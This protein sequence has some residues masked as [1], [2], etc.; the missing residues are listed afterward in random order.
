MRFLA[1]LLIA[2]VVVSTALLLQWLVRPWLADAMPDVWLARALVAI[3][4]LAI[5]FLMVVAGFVMTHH[6]VEIIAFRW[7]RQ[8]ATTDPSFFPEK[9]WFRQHYERCSSLPEKEQA[10]CFEIW[11][12]NC[13]LVKEIIKGRKDMPEEEKAEYLEEH[14]RVWRSE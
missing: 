6:A 1:F 13:D 11:G 3:G 4:A 9:E 12:T 2:V 5:A 10:R 8:R 14:A 7:Q